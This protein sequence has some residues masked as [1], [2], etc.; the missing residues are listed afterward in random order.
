MTGSDG[1][2]SGGTSA[3]ASAREREREAEPRRRAAGRVP[4][5]MPP[6]SEPSAKHASA[7]P[8]CAREPCSS[9]KAGIETSTTPKAAPSANDASMTVR[10]AG[11]TERARARMR[12]PRAPPAARTGGAS[13][14]QTVPIPANAAAASDRQPRAAPTAAIAATITGRR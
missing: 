3:S 2:T 1:A 4:I 9:P 8:P 5:Q 10:T 13:A 11:G 6:I 14:N 7:K 12:R